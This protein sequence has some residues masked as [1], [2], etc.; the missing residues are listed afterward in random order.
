MAKSLTYIINDNQEL[1]SN[2]HS[3]IGKFWGELK[4][5]VNKEIEDQPNHPVLMKTSWGGFFSEKKLSLWID[6]NSYYLVQCSI[7]RAVLASAKASDWDEL[8]QLIDEAINIY[9][10]RNI[11]ISEHAKQTRSKIGTFQF[12]GDNKPGKWKFGITRYARNNDQ[13]GG[14]LFG[15]VMGR[16]LF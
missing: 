9:G 3:D 8:K 1:Y 10:A 16:W 2:E 12:S 6:V 5:R 11:V 7:N 15:F 4:N 14:A 13:A